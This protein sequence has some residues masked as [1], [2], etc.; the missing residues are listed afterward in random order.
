M[1]STKT[2][3]EQHSDLEHR[4]TDCHRPLRARLSI[5]AGAGR[6]PS[7]CPSCV[8]WSPHGE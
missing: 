4:C 7:T 1:F 8:K 2:P 3:A 6:V 5:A